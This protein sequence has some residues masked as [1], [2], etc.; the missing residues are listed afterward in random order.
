MS[1]QASNLG[2]HM[3]VVMVAGVSALFS[4]G[5]MLALTPQPLRLARL[6]APGFAP[7]A[8]RAPSAAVL[9][10]ADGH[11]WAE[12]QVNGE[13]VRFLVDTGATAV[14]LTPAD[15]ERLGFRPQDLDYS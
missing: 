3:Q 2:K 6:D 9:K 15:A 11:F 8:A 4:A 12:G 13:P 5:A 7:A 14:A 1:N 10:G